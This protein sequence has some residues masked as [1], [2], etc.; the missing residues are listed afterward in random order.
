MPTRRGRPP[1][2]PDEVKEAKGNPGHRPLNDRR[3][4]P[5]AAPA[6]VSPPVPL[7]PGA[8]KIWKQTVKMMLE[9][10]TLK[11]TDVFAVATFANTTA[12]LVHYEKLSAKAG[13]LAVI[14]GFRGQVK[15]LRM[16]QKQLMGELALT[17][18]S[19]SGVKVEKAKPEGKL[20]KFRKKGKVVRGAFGNV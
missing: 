4:D 14:Q 15:W 5:P 16:Q 17:P 6:N 13:D 8:L 7:V 1:R 20:G 12:E 19:R 18:S 10:G 3:P 11:T 2:V 9:A